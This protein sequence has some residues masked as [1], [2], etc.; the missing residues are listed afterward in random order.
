MAS[1]KRKGQPQSKV[2]GLY[3]ALGVI[4]VIGIAGLAFALL[5]AGADTATAPVEVPGADDPQALVAAARGVRLGSADAPVTIIEFGD[6]QCPGCGVFASRVKPVLKQR[7]IDSGQAQFIY[8]D[9]P[10]V[11]IHAN[12][13][14]AARAA[15]CAEDQGKF[16]EYHDLVFA[17]QSDWSTERNAEETFIELG[18]LVGLDQETFE[19]CVRSDAHAELVSANSALGDKLGV[20]ST[21]TLFVNGKRVQDWETSAIMRVIDQELGS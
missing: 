11:S 17:R 14:L 7:Y 10:L 3:L 20:A 4:A 2:K 13:F 19:D 9:F 5:R 18:S 15:R 1:G 6:Y 16:W 8:Y 21:P 12:A